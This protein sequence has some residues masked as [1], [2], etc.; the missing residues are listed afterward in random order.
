[1]KT[2][3]KAHLDGEPL[4]R[5]ITRGLGLVVMGC[6]GLFLTLALLNEDPVPPQGR[7]VLACLAACLLGAGLTWRWARLGGILAVFAAVALGGAVLYS[8]LVTGLGLWAVGLALAYPAPFFVVGGLAL[9][10]AG[11]GGERGGR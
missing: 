6:Y 7:P 2:Q 9:S 1:M 10:E 5:W 3:A 4:V 11:A 8:G